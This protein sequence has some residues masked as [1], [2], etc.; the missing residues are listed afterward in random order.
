MTSQRDLIDPASRE[1]LEQ[2]VAAFPGGFNAIP[3][4]VE[5]RAVVSGLLAAMA[6]NQ[7]PNPR[8][9]TQDRMAPAPMGAPGG[10]VRRSRPV[11]RE[12]A[13]PAGFYIHGG[14]MIL[15]SIE[16]EATRSEL[17][18]ESLGAVIVSTDYRKAPEHPHPAQ[19]NDCYAALLWTAAHAAELGIDPHRLAIYGPS[20]G[21]NLAIA[22]SM[23]VRDSGGPALRLLMA[24]YP[25]VDHTH[26][27]V[28]NQRITDVGIWDRAGNIQAWGWF[29]AGQEPDA[30]AAPLHAPDLSGLPPTFIDVGTV[31]LFLDEDIALV[32]RLIASGV[33]TEFHI[34]PGAYHASEVFAMTAD[35]SQRIWSLRLAALGRA[36]A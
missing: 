36:L 24:P 23:K 5:R 8:V 31:D 19:V 13:R 32:A 20:A 35:L 1:P 16:A 12:G 10:P 22:T 4:I 6:A 26:S 30:Y 27:T 14:G 11:G 2:L 3:D 15:G 18:C 25:M 21:G 34:H 7:P 17:L 28:S 33:P 29:L 9:T